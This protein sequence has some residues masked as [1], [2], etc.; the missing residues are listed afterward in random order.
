MLGDSYLRDGNEEPSLARRVAWHV[1][2]LRRT[3]YLRAPF[4]S[5]LTCAAPRGRSDWLSVRHNDNSRRSHQARLARVGRGRH[6]RLT[7]RC[8]QRLATGTA[9]LAILLRVRSADCTRGADHS[10]SWSAGRRLT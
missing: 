6:R 2:K 9:R 4:T 1:R 5:I 8:N 10:A 3:A 7:R